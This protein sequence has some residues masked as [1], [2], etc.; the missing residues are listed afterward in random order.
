MTVESRG[1]FRAATRCVWFLSSYDFN[2]REPLVW[3][4]GSPVSIRVARERAAL[5][6]SHGRGIS[7]QAELN[8]ESQGVSRVV[9]GNPGF[10]RLVTVTSG[11]FSG[12]LL[13][14]RNTVG[15][16]GAV[17]IPLCLVE[18]R[19]PHLELR[20][21]PQGSSPVLTW[22]SACVCHFKQGVRFDM[23][24]GIEL[25]FPLE[26]STG[27]QA[28]SRIEFWMGMLSAFHH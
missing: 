3:P 16:G 25:C 2:L 28:S 18:G 10:P 5:L 15:F 20:R 24:G 1:F 21:E 22:V 17:G 13:E 23:C 8:R 19:V 7:P 27:F 14:V 12:C 26:L 9:I 6:S 4:Q 11:S